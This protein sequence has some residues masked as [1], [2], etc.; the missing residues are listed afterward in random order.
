MRLHYQLKII[1]II[2]INFLYNAFNSVYLL[3]LLLKSISN[4]LI[5]FLLVLNKPIPIVI[6]N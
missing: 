3:E 6:I 1:F 4:D 2:A 5:L